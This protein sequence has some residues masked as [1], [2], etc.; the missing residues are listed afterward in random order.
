MC[1][2]ALLLMAKLLDAWAIGQYSFVLKLST[3][4]SYANERRKKL[5]KRSSNHP[6][7]VCIHTYS[8]DA[9]NRSWCSTNSSTVRSY[10]LLNARSEANVEI[11]DGKFRFFKCKCG[12]FSLCSSFRWWRQRKRK[13]ESF[14]PRKSLCW[15]LMKLKF[16]F[17]F[18][19]HTT[20]LTAFNGVMYFLFVEVER[21]SGTCALN[22]N[23]MGASLS[24]WTMCEKKQY[25]AHRNRFRI[26]CRRLLIFVHDS[27]YRFV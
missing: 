12:N 22:G 24:E 7:I 20:K 17:S 5:F 8:N 11:A 3:K 2:A 10:V 1:C 19:S 25:C 21:L 13:G 23:C 27:S 9:R 6:I 18:L 26:P 4:I 15:E 14:I 16:I